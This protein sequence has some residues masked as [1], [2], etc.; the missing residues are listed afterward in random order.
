MA[1]EIIIDYRVYRGNIGIL[2]ETINKLL[3]R[4]VLCGNMPF[5][6]CDVSSSGSTLMALC[7]LGLIEVCGKREQWRLVDPDTQKRIFVNEYRFCSEVICFK[8][9]VKK[10]LMKSYSDEM[11]LLL[12][13]AQKIEQKMAEIAIKAQMV[14]F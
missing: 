8:E 12:Y 5:T 2:K 10:S 13:K 4:Q 3:E 9:K 6:A 1:K 11:D 14:D 7:D